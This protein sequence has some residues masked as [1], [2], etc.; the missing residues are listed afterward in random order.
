[1]AVAFNKLGFVYFARH[2]KIDVIK[3]GFSMQPIYRIENLTFRKRHRG[4]R[5]IGFIRGTRRMEWRL[6][7]QFA[8]H[9]LKAPESQEFYRLSAIETNVSEIMEYRT[10]TLKIVYARMRR[11]FIYARRIL[12]AFGGYEK[13]GAFLRMTPDS[14]ALL[15]AMWSDIEIRSVERIRRR[16]GHPPM[17]GMTRRALQVPEYRPS[18]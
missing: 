11:D 1:M 8:Q 7:K 9:R 10:Q 18:T 17:H 2:P 14:L 5:V 6:H 12:S 16:N 3:V 15:Y 4:F 13:L